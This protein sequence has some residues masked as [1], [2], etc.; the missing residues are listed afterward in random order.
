MILATR[1]DLGNLSSSLFQI[2][3]MPVL[4]WSLIQVVGKTHWE[5][6]KVIKS[7]LQGYILRITGGNDKQGFPMKQGVL[8][9]GRVRLLLSKGHSCYRSRRD[10]ERKRKSVRGCIVDANLSALALIIVKKGIIGITVFVYRTLT[11]L[12]DFVRNL[13]VWM[14]ICLFCLPLSR[15]EEWLVEIIKQ[16]N[17]WSLFRWSTEIFNFIGFKIVHMVQQA[18]WRLLSVSFQQHTSRLGTRFNY[19]YSIISAIP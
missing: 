12:H 13:D 15:S 9:N 19:K 3:L 4:C 2:D 5:L 14:I 8:T 6:K 18:S 11:V 16:Q 17:G 7:F 10:G 1:R